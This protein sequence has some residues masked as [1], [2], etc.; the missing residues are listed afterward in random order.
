MNINPFTRT[1]QKLKI[2]LFI[3]LSLAS[4]VLLAQ[5]EIRGRI[6]SEDDKEPLPGATVLI[7]GTS[8]GSISDYDGSFKLSANPGEVLVVTYIGF[9][10]KEVAVTNA[11]YIEISLEPDI[12]ALDEIIVIGYGTQKK[13]DI[14]GSVASIRQ[15]DFNPGPVVSVSNLLQSTAPG[16]VLTQSSAQPGGN[17]DINI[18]GASSVLGANGP[19]Y[20]I[21]GFPITSDNVQPESNS[22]YRSS[23]PRNPLNGINPQDIVS[24]EIL[25]D[26]SATAIYGARGAN[27]VVLITT[28][29]GRSNKLSIEFGSSFSIQELDNR[30]HMLNATEYAQVSNEVFL[31][32]HPDSDPLYSTDFINNAGTGTDWID[33]ITRTG[34]IQQYQLSASHGINNLKYFISGNYYKHDG[35]V[36]VSSLERYSGK[37]NIDYNIGKLRTGLSTLVSRTN[38]FQVPFGADDGG[39]FEFAGLM[40]NT[41]MWSPLVSVRDADGN[42]SLHPERTEIPNPVSLLEIEDEIN[43]NRLLSTL[44]AEYGLTDNLSVK[45]NLGI[46]KSHSEREALIPTSVIRGAQSKGEGE[47]SENDNQSFLSEFTVTYRKKLNQNSNITILGGSTF[48]QFDSEGTSTLFINFAD[49]TTDFDNITSADTLSVVEFKERSRLMSFIGRINYSA[50]DKYLFTFSFRADGSTKFGPNNKWGYFPSTAVAWKIHN[51]SFFS[52]SFINELKLRVS[53]GLTGNQ[54]I[55]NKRSQSL[56]N[57]TRRTVLGGSP[58]QGLAAL[59]PENSDLQWESTSQFNLGLDFSLLKSRIYGSVDVYR[60]I[61]DDVLLDFELPGTAGFELVTLNAGS[62]QNQGIEL[63]LTSRNLVRR[64]EWTTSFN[65]AYND[66][67]WRDRAGFY[68]E[69]EQIAEENGPLGGIYGY[70]VIGLFSS[71]EEIDSSP[72]QSAVAVAQPGTFKYQDANGDGVVTPDDRVLLGE[73]D[74]DFTFGLNNSFTYKKFDLSFFF[75]GALGQEK[76]NYTRAHLEDVDDINDGFNKT[77]TVLNRWMQ[78]NPDGTVPGQDDLIGGF[79]NNS[80]YIENASFIRLRNITFGYT[81]LTN[82]KISNLRIYG[83]IQNLLTFTSFD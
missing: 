8:N 17:F 12:E 3:F 27:G 22:R 74:P 4:A 42:Y 61:T 69:G 41:R 31:A 37:M 13:S 66:N 81:F 39:G 76:E 55:G 9:V 73:E 18:R 77:T 19:L 51:E 60:K 75:Q 80:V 82:D 35:V 23:P 63:G 59:R 58:V 15:E 78:E 28:K 5:S 65:F 29:R 34:T 47:V 64:L 11:N 45:I 7:K 67:Q 46:D 30:Y 24:V 57:V 33:E 49:E 50:N 10:S 16:V 48:Q 32:N 36:D 26:A 72:N 56:Y 38:D 40:D 71:Q 79:S 25:K 53:Y 2:Y 83:D 68:P 44:F 43:T 54:E 6:V 21:D 1:D 20:V 62:I 52:S 70:R 14:T